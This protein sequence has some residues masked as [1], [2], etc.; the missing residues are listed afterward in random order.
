MPR[1]RKAKTYRY[2]RAGRNSFVGRRVNGWSKFGRSFSKGF[3]GVFNLAS[4]A[5]NT[6]S[7]IRKLINVEYKYIDTGATEI[8]SNTEIGYLPASATYCVLNKIGQGDDKN[9]R[10]GVSVRMSRVAGSFDVY[11]NAAYTGTQC[12]RYLFCIYRDADGGLPDLNKVF[13]SVNSFNT[14]RNREYPYEVSILKQGRVQVD[15]VTRQFV[16]VKYD[17]PLNSH[18][19]FIDAGNDYDSISR[20]MLLFFIWCDADANSPK[21]TNW[22]SRFSYIDN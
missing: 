11:H 17:I 12:V 22:Q 5:L 4:R 20:N 10:N 6:A 21:I 18:E 19:K 2:N 1:Y 14:M 3:N 7:K 13:D 9:E 15:T 8:P 16:H